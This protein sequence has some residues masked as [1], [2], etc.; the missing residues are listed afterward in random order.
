[1]HSGKKEIVSHSQQLITGFYFVANTFI[2][3][4]FR[5]ISFRISHGSNVLF[6]QTQSICP[7]QSGTSRWGE[8]S[9]WP[10]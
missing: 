5:N 4:K 2:H 1:M 6:H 9:S 7:F 8:S 3:T 10:V